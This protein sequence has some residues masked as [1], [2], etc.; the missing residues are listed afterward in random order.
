MGASRTIG[1]AR[2]RV[3]ARVRVAHYSFSRIVSFRLVSYGLGITNPQMIRDTLYVTRP[4]L[5]CRLEGLI[6]DVVGVASR[7]Q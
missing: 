2:V 3:R 6:P 1:L 4:G 5:R 7:E